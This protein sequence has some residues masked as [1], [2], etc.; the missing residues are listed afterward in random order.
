M[1]LIGEIGHAHVDTAISMMT[2]SGFPANS[3]AKEGHHPET[4]STPG[5]SDTNILLALTVSIPNQFQQSRKTI[6][7]PSQVQLSSLNMVSMSGVYRQPKHPLSLLIQR[8][9]LRLH[10]GTK[11]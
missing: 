10:H 1:V 8:R 2:A 6:R 11:R 9:R 3:F 7:E 4:N 5:S